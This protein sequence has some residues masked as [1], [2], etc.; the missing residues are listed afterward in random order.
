MEAVLIFRQP[1]AE[2]W[3]AIAESTRKG[4][5]D[6]VLAPGIVAPD[7]FRT[8]PL[9]AELIS[10]ASSQ[11]LKELLRFG[12]RNIEGRAVS[13]RLSFGKLR[14]WHYQ[15]FRIFFSLKTEYLIFT[16]A[17]HYQGKYD[18]ITL[19]VNKQPTN[20]P[21]SINYITKK[22]RSRDP[23]NLFAW[24][25]YMFYFGIKLLKSGLINPRPE[26]KKHA[27]VDRSLKQWCRHAETLQLK[28]DN[29]TL[30][31]LL[32]QAGDDF[33][34]IS[35]A[36]Q[37]KFRGKTDFPLP[38]RLFGP[39][40][41]RKQTINGE[42]IL[43]KGWL[44]PK[45]RTQIKVWKNQWTN[46]LKLIEN[47]Q[48]SPVENMFL[49][50]LK[51]LSPGNNFFMLKYL[52]FQRFFNKY[53]MLTVSAIDENSPATRCILDAA[54]AEGS[55]R[56]GIQHGNIGNA[57]PAYLYTPLDREA[58]VMA[59]HTLV[60]GPYWRNFLIE[61]GNFL[62]EGIRITGQL[63]TD[64]IPA[65]LSQVESLKRHYAI[66]GKVALFASQPIPDP[67]QRRQAALDVFTAFKQLER[68]ELF[69]KLHPAEHNDV[70]YYRALAEKAGLTKFRLFSGDDLYS[71]LCVSDL[72]ITCYSTVGTE[73]IY[74]NKPLIILDP[75]RED[76]LGYHKAGVAGQAVN[77]LMLE[78]LSKKVLSGEFCIDEEAYH[79]FI[80]NYA[81]R[82]DGQVTKRTLQAIYA[83][84]SDIPH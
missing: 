40:Q 48:L 15:R 37:P 51:A 61:T 1:D 42:C 43:L 62:P 49:G 19:F 8:T 59:D 54:A 35:E 72:V 82:I 66:S 33:L 24:I 68:V 67:A 5:V 17:E 2:E 21:E 14:L 11:L 38:G 41:R 56:I 31:N 27:I 64:V 73:A 80:E 20:L 69:V 26:K 70:N 58:G 29:Y 71:L 13:E 65:M 53:P 63:R 52:S 44:S 46:E 81:Y 22:G 77:A 79:K 74:F 34:I 76:L 9:S 47:E 36:E 39:A 84:G 4:E 50:A 28:R 75:Q 3:K 16:A 12:D 57:Q 25:K 55:K 60:W 10:R 32:D 83:A 23:L 78:E 18:R 45:V 7:D 30:G 6:V